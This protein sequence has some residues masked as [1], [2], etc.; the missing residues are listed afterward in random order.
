MPIRPG[1]TEDEQQF[2]SR[3]MSVETKDYPQ[4]QAYAICKSKWDRKELSKQKFSDP[5]RRVMSKLNFE[6]KYRGINLLA[7][8]DDDPCQ[9]GYRQLGTKMLD[10]KDVPNC[11]PEEDHPDTK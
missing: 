2:I 9:T 8:P 7:K 11:I 3:C 4:D 5:Q 1:K 6:E 10:G